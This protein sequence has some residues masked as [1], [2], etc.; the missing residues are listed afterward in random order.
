MRDIQRSIRFDRELCQGCMDC[1][2]FCP[3][4][5]IRIRANKAVLIGEL[6]IDCGECVRLCKRN[7]IVPLTSSIGELS[8]FKYTIA[9]PSPV[10]YS[11]FGRD[12]SPALV[13]EA[14]KKAGFN[15]AY[16]VA[17][18]SEA[19]SFA[20][21]EFLKTPQTKRPLISSF[22]PTI[23]RL[24]QIRY[25]NLIDHLIPIESPMEIAAREAKR[26]K[27]KELGL[28]E[29]EIGAIYITPCPAKMISIKHPPRKKHSFLDG[30]IGISEVF[31]LL[32]QALPFVDG[33]SRREEIRGL[34][35]GWPI[36]GGQISSLKAA[37]CLAIGGLSD[38]IR[39]FDEIENG[40]LKEIQFI[41]CHSCPTACVGGPLTVENPYLARGKVLKLVEKY[42]SKP[43]REKEFYQQLYNKKYF[44][45][46]GKIN[47]SPVI[48]LDTDITKAIE[49]MQQKQKLFETLP[50]IDC[51]ICGS[52]TCE[53]F[54]EDVVKGFSS[55][56]DCIILSMKK[57]EEISGELFESAQRH[58]RKIQKKWGDGSS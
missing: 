16:D 21:E 26:L 52:P 55:E 53:I 9:I 39:I 54:A 38:A 4:H 11:Q 50:K 28:R 10:L 15:D 12:A 47:A 1:M 51:G 32:L 37:D 58:S 35:L 42:G 7:A 44:S 25:P 2:R 48:P 56:D 33:S 6:C 27:M 13:L 3:T 29:N 23:M 31:P 20:I 14:L 5:A 34:G 18:A 49:M 36:F 46:P 43:C 22:C 40:K 30:A 45:L 24:I 41:E 57:F 19:V 17:C 8:R